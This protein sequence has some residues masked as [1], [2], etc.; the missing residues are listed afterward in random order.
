MKIRCTPGWLCLMLILSAGSSLRA[1]QNTVLIIA[2]DVS[3]DYFGCFSTGTDTA[4]T[5]VIRSLAVQGVRFSQAWASPVCSPTRACLLTG[6]YSFRNGVGGVVMGLST[7][8]IDTAEMSIAKLLKYQAPANYRTACVGKWH[9]T[10]N[11]PQRRLYPNKM[12]FDLYSGNFLGAITDYYRYPRVKNG[13]TDTVKT[14]ATTQ[15]VNDALEWLD[16]LNSKRPFF[17]WLAFNAPHTPFHVPPAALCDTTGLSGSSADISANPEKYFKA[18]LQAMDTEIGRLISSLKTR[19]LYDSTNFIF[20]GD[21][22]NSVQVAQIS[23]RSRSKGTIYHYG[24]NVPMFITGPAVTAKGSIIGSPVSTSDLYATIAEMSGL[25]DWRKYIP[26]G[27]ITDSRSLL[28]VL[29]NQG[30]VSRSWVF[31][32]TFNTP[33]TADD[34]KTIRNSDY[35]LLRFDDGRE[36][37]YRLSADPQELSNLL[38]SPSSMTGAD[39]NNYRLLCDSISALTGISGC[40]SLA[41]EPA[42][43]DAAFSVYPNPAKDRVMFRLPFAGTA[44]LSLS[45]PCGRTVRQAEISDGAEL[46]ISGLQDGIYLVQLQQG[47]RQSSRKLLIIR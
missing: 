7:P 19:K 41:L 31:T 12:G 21:N 18:A 33:A 38:L 4:K 8:Q 40:Q 32:E 39:L 27:K 30:S 14:Y 20:I 10:A 15:T 25:P 34:G 6:R 3:P 43:R 26:S 42:D 1:Q 36:E 23:N 22:G 29:K 16:T 28:P 9:L 46:E 44:M 13:I 11:T 24:V 2:D 17:L 35:H 37:F 45:D 5:P 47:G